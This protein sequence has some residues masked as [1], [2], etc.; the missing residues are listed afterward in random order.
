MGKINDLISKPIEVD[1]RGEKYSLQAGFTIE[2]TPAIQMAFGE[3]SAKDRAEGMKLLLK[4]IL[5][6]LF[7]E[8]SEEE[9]SQFDAKYAQDLMEVFFQMDE[10]TKKDIKN[11]KNILNKENK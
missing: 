9:I 3:K 6:R 8:A 1:F 2:E 7:P 5:R 4:V 10:S 11:V